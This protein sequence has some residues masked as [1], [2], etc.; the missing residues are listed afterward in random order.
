MKKEAMDM[1][2]RRIQ[3]GMD[4]NKE[5]VPKRNARSARTSTRGRWRREWGLWTCTSTGRS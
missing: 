3:E 5:L 2:M 1:Y 4:M